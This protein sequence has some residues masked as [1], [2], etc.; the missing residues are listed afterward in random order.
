MWSTTPAERNHLAIAM[1]HML[2][3]LTGIN[4]AFRDIQ[5]F[6][7]TFTHPARPLSTLRTPRCHDARKTR[8][9]PADSGYRYLVRRGTAQN[10]CHRGP[11]SYVIRK[12]ENRPEAA[13]H[14]RSKTRNQH[15]IDFLRSTGVAGHGADSIWSTSSLSPNQ[16]LA[17]C[18]A[19]S[20]MS[21]VMWIATIASA[22]TSTPRSSP[23]P[24][25]GVKSGIASTASC[26]K[27]RPFRNRPLNQELSVV[28]PPSSVGDVYA[29]LCKRGACAPFSVERRRRVQKHKRTQDQRAVGVLD[30][31][32]LGLVGN[33]S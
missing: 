17:L 3:S 20:A 26:A 13:D 18:L 1:A 29:S 23:Y 8:S 27:T 9:R 5:H 28:L 4:S 21:G 10:G 32:C 25:A 2:P 6:E 33:G 24:T 30:E 22:A 7:A 16:S 14:G 31:R 11:P 12:K 19:F 15:W